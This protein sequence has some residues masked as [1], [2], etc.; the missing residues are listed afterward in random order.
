[1][2]QLGP[3]PLTELWIAA[4]PVTQRDSGPVRVA[5]AEQEMFGR[6]A[7]PPAGQDFETAVG[8]AYRVLGTVV[9]EA[10][11]PY[12]H[13]IWNYFGGIHDMDAGL[14]RYQRFCRARQPPLL[15]H[16]HDLRDGFPA[17]TAIGHAGE[18]GVVYFMAGRVPGHHQENP[19]QV[20]AYDY[21]PRYGPQSPSFA[22]ATLVSDGSAHALYISGTASIVGH[23]SRH[24]ADAAAQFS[25]T[26]SNVQEVIAA[27]GSAGDCELTGIEVLRA[28]KIYLR[29]MEDYEKVRDLAQQTFA[30]VPQMFIQGELCRRELLL[31]IEA[32]A[33]A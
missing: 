8:D 7:L 20:S 31:E 19:R 2:R 30:D 26:V 18:G 32:F 17:A 5:C 23:E 1:M 11:Y 10:G 6:I 27:A 15:A 29:R 22:R 3:R 33:R 4:R 24:H 13:R 25:E 28:V 21:P 12:F 9:T 14:D 16:C